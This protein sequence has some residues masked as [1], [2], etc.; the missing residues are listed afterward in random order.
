[1]EHGSGVG[2]I[3]IDGKRGIPKYWKGKSSMR[4]MGE[5]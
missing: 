1:M 5:K 3:R 4:G 2:G